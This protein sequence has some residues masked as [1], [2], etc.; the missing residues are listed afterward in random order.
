MTNPRF[1]SP[2]D[3][4]GPQYQEMIRSKE[5]TLVYLSSPDRKLRLA[6]ILL[7]E[8]VWNAGRDSRVIEACR[9]IAESD[10]DDSYRGVAVSS[11][12][13]ALDSSKARDASAF[14]ANLIL[15]SSESVELRRDAYW[16]LRQIQFGVADVDFDTFF[17]GT[18]RM[19]KTIMRELPGRFSEDEVIRDLTPQPG[20]PDNF[21]DSADRI[22]LDFVS[23]FL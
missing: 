17:M 22:D 16:A 19:V 23:Q 12:G 5:A 3:L 4:A 6:A 2:K 9:H 1:Q 11:L 15:D 13:T 18:I 20:F 21:W 10:A 14:L 7:C 8:A